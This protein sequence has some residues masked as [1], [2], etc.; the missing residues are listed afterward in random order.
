MDVEDG[1]SSLVPAT[2]AA[3]AGHAYEAAYRLSRRKVAHHFW[4]SIQALLPTTNIPEPLQPEIRP[5][6]R[7]GGTRRALR[8]EDFAETF[9]VGCGRAR[10]GAVRYKELACAQEI[11]VVDGIDVARRIDGMPPHGKT[12]P[13]RSKASSAVAANPARIL[14]GKARCATVRSIRA[15]YDRDLRRLFPPATA[16]EIILRPFIP[17]PHRLGAALGEWHSGTGE[18]AYT[19][20]LVLK[21]MIQRCRE[22]DFRA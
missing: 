13:R 9:A 21:D 10:S 14:S 11:G 19:I 20:N 22:L 15:F 16:T 12:L 3:W 18:Y 5:T 17:A 1:T 4:P 8:W 2:S 7:F 6:P